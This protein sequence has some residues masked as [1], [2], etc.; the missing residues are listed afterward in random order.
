MVGRRQWVLFLIFFFSCPTYSRAQ[1]W[2]GILDPS[3]AID[4]TTAG[5]PGGIPTLTTICTTWYSGSGAPSNQTGNNGDYYFRTDVGHG[6]A[7]YKKSSGTWSAT[8]NPNLALI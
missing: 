4:W 7:E 3:R 5:I 8:G 6:N 1:A 2:A